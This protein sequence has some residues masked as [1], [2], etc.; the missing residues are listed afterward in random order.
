[1]RENNK[2]VSIVVPIYNGA[3][4]IDRCVTN[5]INQ[6]Y[7]NIEII[8]I[9]DGSTDNSLEILKDYCRKYSNLNVVSKENTGVSFTRNLGVKLAK[10]DYIYFY[11]V[12]DDLEATTIEDNMKLI[13]DKD[14]D[15]IYFGFWYHILDEN[16]IKETNISS[17]FEGNGHEFFKKAFPEL[18]QKEILN[19]P[20]NKLYKRNF[21]IWNR[22]S[23]DENLSIYEDI[24]FNIKALDRANNIMV[25]PKPYYHYMIQASGTA[26]TRFHKNNYESV[27]KIHIAGMDYA[28]RYK[29]NELVISYY[30]NMFINQTASFL[31][32]L[33]NKKDM[34]KQ[35]RDKLIE[36]IISDD[37]FLSIINST[38]NLDKRKVF[39]KAFCNHNLKSFVKLM[40]KLTN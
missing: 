11:D 20:W 35:E 26:L 24:L 32:Q 10:G 14:V 33:V 7:K 30:D 12:D 8:M 16:I 13:G 23:F 2:L 38:Q 31:K 28:K 6:T 29:D 34:D 15:I 1:M 21:L 19:S 36:E 27:K 17:S 9:N 37:Y 5:L 25:N 22:I 18:M 4:Y 40:Y 3:K 39:L